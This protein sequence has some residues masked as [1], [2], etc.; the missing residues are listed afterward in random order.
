MRAL[1]LV[2]DCDRCAALCCVW[3]SF[4]ASPAFAYSKPAGEECVHLRANRCRIHAQKAARGFAGC[5]A[6]DCHGAGQR[7]TALFTREKLGDRE[8]HDVFAALR[9]LH[10]LAWMLRGAMEMFAVDAAS[11]LARLEAIA[12]GDVATVLA[13][14]LPA[15][16]I[17]ARTLLR[18]AR[19]V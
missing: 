10:E 12:G 7:A 4:E 3:I 14:D 13:A 6:F 5:A 15:L 19:R 2:A 18:S 16:R 17:H 1:E 9:E 11:L 8:K